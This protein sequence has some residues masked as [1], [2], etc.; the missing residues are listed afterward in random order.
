MHVHRHAKLDESINFRTKITYLLIIKHNQT[1]PE[2]VT[3]N[4]K[5]ET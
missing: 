2:R 3:G 4:R 5:V 1:Q